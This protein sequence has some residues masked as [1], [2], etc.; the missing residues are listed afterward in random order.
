[1][2]IGAA[3]S[4]HSGDTPQYFSVDAWGGGPLI[5]RQVGALPEAQQ[6]QQQQE[7]EGDGW[8]LLQ[9]LLLVPDEC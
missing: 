9:L 7:R 2:F 1:M 5:S 6:Q 8:L 3:C 4:Q